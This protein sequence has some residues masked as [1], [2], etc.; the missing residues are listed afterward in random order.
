[1]NTMTINGLNGSGSVFKTFS[2]AASLTVGDNNADGNFTGVIS[3]F[4]NLTIIK[5]GTGTQ[6]LAGANTYTG[7]TTV[8]AGTL[9]INGSISA[10][11]NVSVT[12]G[13]L[14]GA[15]N[16]TTNGI[17]GGNTTLSAGAKLS[18]G[19]AAGLAGNLTFS[20]GLNLSASS[21]NTGAYLFNLDTVVSSDKITLTSGTAL[22]LNVGTLD[23]TDFT[24]TTT[25]NF[26]TGTYVLFDAN[27]TINGS[28][29]AADT[30]DFGGGITGT[31]SIDSVNNDVLLTVVPEP[32]VAALTLLGALGFRNRR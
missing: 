4:G 29:G 32:S 21:N 2:N 19:A 13:T 22:A 6:I 7:G 1:V 20:N 25:G 12:S 17:I 27:S 23:V 8:N 31:L 24:F 5:T 16:G 26:T 28:I 30:Y 15:G 14:G 9:L 11:G 10:T 18:P 3:N